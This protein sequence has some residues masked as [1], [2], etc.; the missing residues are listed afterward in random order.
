M[1]DLGKARCLSFFRFSGS[2]EEAVWAK[3]GE[4]DS[5]ATSA[6]GLICPV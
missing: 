3:D 5:Q 2:V 1:E 4:R 6:E